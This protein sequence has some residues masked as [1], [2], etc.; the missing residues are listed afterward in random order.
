MI[1]AF[2][3][4]ALFSPPAPASAPASDAAPPPTATAPGSEAPAPEDKAPGSEAQATPRLTKVP[5][6]LAQADA[7]R[8]QT[9]ADEGMRAFE[10]RQ[11]ALARARFEDAFLLAPKPVLL[12]NLARS[13]EEQGDAEHA[14]LCYQRFLR[15]WPDAS[16]AAEVRRRSRILSAVLRET[17]PGRIAVLDAPAG[18]D[19]YIDDAPA[20][21]PVASGWARAPGQYALKLVTDT[22]TFD[23][24]VTVR[25]GETTAVSWIEPDRISSQA[26]LGWTSLGLG[27]A[28]L[29]TSA[30]TWSESHAAADRWYVHVERLQLGDLSPEVLSAKRSAADAVEQYGV[31]TQALWIS[32]GLA[33]TAGLALLLFDAPADPTTVGL[34][35]LPEGAALGGRF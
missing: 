7:V 34:V 32:G 30:W 12:Y 29:G 26:I 27:A 28:L 25:P 10:N 5:A 17:A 2:L 1:D 21:A 13:A 18:A 35:P 14:L 8:A 31:A 16:D 33:L 3:V 24:A 4:L 20:E 9:L 23:T 11:F 15:Q 22:G 19:V 6:T